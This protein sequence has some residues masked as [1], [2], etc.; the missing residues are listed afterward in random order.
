MEKKQSDTDHAWRDLFGEIKAQAKIMGGLVGLL[1]AIQIINAIVFGGRLAAL[2]IHPRTL[3]GL[4]GILFAPL[5]HGSFAHLLANTLPFALLGAIVM[6]RKKRYLAIVSAISAIIG[7]LGVWL[8]GASA[9]VH[10][11]ASILIF[12]YLGYLIS[13]G[14][15]ER[16]VWPI[17]GSVA[18][19]L[20]YGSAL[21]G[22][23]PNQIGVS[24]EG[25]LFGLIGGIVAAR[26]L[27]DRAP[28]AEPDKRRIAASPKARI[29]PSPASPA[30]AAEDDELDAQIERLRRRGS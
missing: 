13:R 9:S 5:L 21:W 27:R 11:G 26:L 18:V 23:L 15:F 30:E 19:F 1:W 17:V 8:I 16:R 20:L 7:G 24:W 10:V 6:Q 25:H 12:G 3:Y 2:G 14:F 22:V 29:A 28:G 4:V